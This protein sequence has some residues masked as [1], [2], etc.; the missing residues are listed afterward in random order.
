[1]RALARITGW[2]LAAL[3]LATALYIVA[4]LLLGALPRNSGFVETHDGVPIFVRTNGVHAEIIVPSRHALHDWTGEFPAQHMASLPQPTEWIAFGWG[5]R[6]FMLTTPTWAD[7]RPGTAIVALSGLGEGV[8][9]VEYVETPLAYKARRVRLAPEEYQ[10]LVAAI[11]ASFARDSSGAVRKLDAP[12]YF[13]FDAFYAAE[14][15]Y[16]FWYT[17]NEWT[18][19]MLAAAGVRTATW[20]PFDTAVMFHLP[21][22]AKQR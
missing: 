17:C 19:R 15:R 9:H 11:R 13:G 14:P 7:L 16:T 20:A 18:R 8:M 4:A 12:G 1:V 3:L 21:A 5:D 6:G 22:E 10:R 2:A